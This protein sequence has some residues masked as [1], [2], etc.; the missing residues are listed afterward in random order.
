M[1]EL[2]ID[3]TTEYIRKLRFADPHQ[4]EFQML[5]NLLTINETYFFRDFPQ[6]QAFAE[7]CLPEVIERKLKEKNRKIRFWSAGCASGEEPYTIG[8]ILKEMIDDIHNWDIEIIASDIDSVMIE[9]AKKGIYEE[10]SIRDVPKEYLTRYFT[11]NKDKYILCNDIK[12]MVHFEHLNLGNKEQVRGRKG[13]DMIFCR[14]VL[15]Y[16]DD[17]S[18]KQL[19]DQF[20]LSLNPGGFIF[21]GSSESVGRITTAF[22]IKRAGNHLVY[23]K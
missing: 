20:Y 19:V 16:F 13:F 22:K 10:R 7:H 14:N 12:Q 15:I 21:L 18:R 23:Y 17:I 6:L 5:L 1:A 2:G 3:S 11:K 9:K 4:T 8:I